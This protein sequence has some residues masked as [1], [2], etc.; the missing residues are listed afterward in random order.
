MDIER[1]KK[2]T[3]SNVKAGNITKRVRTVLKDYEHSKQDVQEELSGTFKPIV[4]A[5]KEAKERIDENQNKMLEQLQKK[6]KAITSG[7]E[8]LALMQQC[9]WLLMMYNKKQPNYQLIINQL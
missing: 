9:L 1:I 4:K 2:M 6:Q 8:D 5:Q 3:D 7:L